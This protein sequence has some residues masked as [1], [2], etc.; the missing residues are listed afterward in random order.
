M[1]PIQDKPLKAARTI[2]VDESYQ[3]ELTELRKS[4]NK[5]KGGNTTG[6]EVKVLD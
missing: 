6:D 3:M 4:R 2:E 5:D 1:A